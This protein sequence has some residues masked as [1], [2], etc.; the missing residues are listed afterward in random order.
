MDSKTCKACGESKP[1]DDYY[2]AKSNSDGRQS[3]CK[4]CTKAH[5]RKLHAANPEARR[6][7]Y[8]ENRA[9]SLESNA[10][11]RAEHRE[12]RAEYMAAYRAKPETAARVAEYY[13]SN[14]EAILAQQAEN[15]HIRWESGYRRRAKQYGHEHLI[16]SMESFT[17]AELI[18]KWGDACYL[19]GGDWDQLEHVTPVSRGG[20]HS[21]ENCR[22]ACEPC[23]RRAW[24]E[25]RRAETA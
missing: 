24:A 11:W 20:E 16:P 21:L 25:Y 6:A 12:Y 8:W 9:R 10:A 19:C 17:R 23:N 14:R 22:P 3:R 4:S 1:L 15:P 5:M 18:A 13:V 2:R 7:R